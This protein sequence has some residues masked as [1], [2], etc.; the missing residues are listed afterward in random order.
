MARYGASRAERWVAGAAAGL[1]RLAPP[2]LRA[3]VAARVVDVV[4]AYVCTS[5]VC[6]IAPYIHGFGRLTEASLP[7]LDA[8]PPTLVLLDEDDVAIRA[9]PNFAKISTGC[10]GAR[11]ILHF[12]GTMKFGSRTGY[13]VRESARGP[14]ADVREH[15]RRHG[16]G[17]PLLLAP[18]P[19]S[20]ACC[21]RVDAWARGLTLFL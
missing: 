18:E 9:V 12:E 10:S 16:P 15:G 21:R 6:R 20:R 1:L 11:P 2:P 19:G 17:L 3:A 13:D 14:R 8:R 4:F 7:P 5:D